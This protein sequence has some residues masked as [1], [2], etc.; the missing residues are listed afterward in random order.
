ML[1]LLESNEGIG[2]IDFNCNCLIKKP[3]SLP[4]VKKDSADTD[5]YPT[6]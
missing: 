5:P 4:T 6:I 3:F 1:F 2:I